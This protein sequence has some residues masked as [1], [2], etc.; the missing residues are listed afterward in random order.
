ML[1][2]AI[3]RSQLIRSVVR[4]ATGSTRTEESESSVS[5]R[6]MDY[7]RGSAVTDESIGSPND[8]IKR[9]N[10]GTRADLDMQGAVRLAP[11]WRSACEHRSG[12]AV[13]RGATPTANHKEGTVLKSRWS[14]LL[15]AL[16]SAAIPMVATSTILRAGEVA[17]DDAGGICTDLGCKSGNDKCA[18]GT[19]TYTDGKKAT[20]TCYTTKAAS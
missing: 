10:I 5:A 20:Y 9:P 3:S 12:P 16:V 14:A 19:I 13:V 6:F 18:D 4:R 2:S 17:D 1:A 7:G 11:R 8:L 15:A